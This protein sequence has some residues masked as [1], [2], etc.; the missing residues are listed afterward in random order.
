[1]LFIVLHCAR[2]QLRDGGDDDDLVENVF[3]IF[4]KLFA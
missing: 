3:F 1:M 4:P 2:S